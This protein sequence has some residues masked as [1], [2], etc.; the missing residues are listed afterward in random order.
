MLTESVS[1]RGAQCVCVC[2]SCCSVF[3]SQLIAKRHKTTKCVVGPRV[4][5]S[6]AVTPKSDSVKQHQNSESA[7]RRRHQQQFKTLCCLVTSLKTHIHHFLDLQ[8]SFVFFSLFS[9]SS[10]H[11]GEEW[12]TLSAQQTSAVKYMLN[13]WNGFTHNVIFIF[14]WT[15]KCDALHVVSLCR[16]FFK[17]LHQRSDMN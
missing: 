1:L 9:T 17:L 5:S 15:S 16:S 12:N 14:W 3:C 6:A 7:G 13:I 2:H 10:F 8:S 4:H 11:W